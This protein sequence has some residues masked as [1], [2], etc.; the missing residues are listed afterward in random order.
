MIIPPAFDLVNYYRS[1]DEFVNDAPP[2]I[3]K[4]LED[5]IDTD[6]IVD[7]FDTRYSEKQIIIF[8]RINSKL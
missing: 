7:C 1:F 2:S 8:E 4:Y 6:D 3:Q 5:L